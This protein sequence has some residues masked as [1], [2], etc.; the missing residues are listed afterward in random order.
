M[1]NNI[2]TYNVAVF[3]TKLFRSVEVTKLF[4]NLHKHYIA[5][6]SYLLND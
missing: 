4:F 1:E 3:L 2:L 5:S 6:T